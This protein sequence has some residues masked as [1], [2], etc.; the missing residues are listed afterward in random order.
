MSQKITFEDKSYIEVSKS[1]NPDMVYITVAAKNADNP[2]ELVVNCVEL[3][4]A[5][6]LTL[7]HSV[8]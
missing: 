2:R 3:S 4:L 8:S 6:L 5:Q 7:L 1:D